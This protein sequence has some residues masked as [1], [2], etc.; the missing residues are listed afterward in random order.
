MKGER[1]MPN[2]SHA[3][4]LSIEFGAL[5]GDFGPQARAVE[6]TLAFK[7]AETADIVAKVSQT[8]VDA[9][10]A[11]NPTDSPAFVT[12]QD[13]AISTA[14]L[15]AWLDAQ[16]ARIPPGSPLTLDGGAVEQGCKLTS[17]GWKKDK[18]FNLQVG[19]VPWTWQDAVKIYEQ[20]NGPISAQA[21][22]ELDPVRMVLFVSWTAF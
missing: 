9:W 16:L 10:H 7:D 18:A 1:F 13:G 3:K 4:N 22:A 8:L 14:D 21:K 2:G 20:N 17:E 11:I 19:G 5:H 6:K 12:D 15:I